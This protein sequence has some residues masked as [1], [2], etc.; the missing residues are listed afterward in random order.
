[1]GGGKVRFIGS[2]VRPDP[3]IRGHALRVSH[4]FESL[5]AMEKGWKVF[6]HVEGAGQ[7][8]IL[9]N[10]DH[11]PVDGLYPTD[12][13]QPGQFVEDSYTV[14]VPA[15][16]PEELVFYIGFYRFDD[17]LPVDERAAHDGANRLP[18]LRVKVGSGE[19]ADLPVYKALRRRA[20]IDLDGDLSD[21]G[22]QG[23]PS[24]GAF[25]RTND[26]G[27]PR[28][29]TEARL[30]WDEEYLWAAF[31]VQDEDLWARSEKKDDPIYQE[32]VVELF[33]DADGD[34]KTYNELELS[35][36]NVQFDAYFPARRQGMDLAW[37]S[38]MTSAVKLRGTLNEP[39][40]KDEG[41]TAELRIPVKR[42]AAVPR[43]PPQPG[44]RWRFN[45]Y[46]LEWHTERKVNEGAA[47]SPPLVG[48]F[49]HLPRFGILELAP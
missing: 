46:R 33:L 2:D 29:R 32:E 28:S 26:G 10:A 18:A 9:I 14:T 12:K 34:G 7:P 20:E 44:D 40:D 8:G 13:W 1:L 35:P 43:W 36:R 45:L 38:Q 49:H 6:V 23:V 47:F 5:A 17:L 22:W 19:S 24:T 25:R 39:T 27:Q 30:V 11:V 48:D 42:L 37:D 15:A 21:P 4:Y 16:A 31:D 3:A 41:W